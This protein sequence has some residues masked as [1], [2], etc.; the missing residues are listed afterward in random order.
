MKSIYRVDYDKKKSQQ[1]NYQAK[2]AYQQ[3]NA[4][5]YDETT[6]N[7]SY[8]PQ[9]IDVHQPHCHAEYRPNSAK[10]NASTTY[11]DQYTGKSGE[12]ACG[13]QKF[14][15]QENNLPFYSH[16]T[17]GDEYKKHKVDVEKPNGCCHA[18][19][20]PNTAKFNASTTYRD[21]FTGKQ[22]EQACG[23]EKFAYQ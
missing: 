2:Y 8:V 11:K 23:K 22:G 17:Y 4:Q 7:K 19:Y 21:K 3:N 1:E 15:Y 20:R 9:K 12:Q 10:F 13:K 16:T 14:A 5:F 18:E 6:D